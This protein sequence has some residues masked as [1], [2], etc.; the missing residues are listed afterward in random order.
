ME[1]RSVVVL[2]R[3]FQVNRLFLSKYSK[4]RWAQEHLQS[5]RRASLGV[6]LVFLG[7]LPP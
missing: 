3:T 2:D 5:H 4:E 6:L 1:Q 7:S